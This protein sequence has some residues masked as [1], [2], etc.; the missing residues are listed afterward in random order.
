MTWKHSSFADLHDTEHVCSVISRISGSCRVGTIDLWVMD[1]AIR[2]LEI[3]IF[4]SLFVATIFFDEI[5]LYFIYTHEVSILIVLTQ[6][7]FIVLK[8]SMI[9][10]IF[11]IGLCVNSFSEMFF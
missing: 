3:E 6:E 4:P 7:Y 8:L 11:R 2:T 5:L 10:P 1:S 9:C